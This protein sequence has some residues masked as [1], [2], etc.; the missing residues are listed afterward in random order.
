M[1]LL[2]YSPYN[3]DLASVHRDQDCDSVRDKDNHCHSNDDYYYH[4][5][6]HYHKA[7]DDH[8]GRASD[9][10]RLIDRSIQ[11]SSLRRIEEG[12]LLAFSIVLAELIEQRDRREGLPD[13]SALFY[14][15]L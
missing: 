8:D 13:S 2:W 10:D 1:R 15:D 6:Y 12:I 11:P 5:H 14:K 4:Y 3:N 9:N 7:Y